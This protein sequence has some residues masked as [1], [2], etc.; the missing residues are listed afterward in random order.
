MN[1]LDTV[2]V[3][4]IEVDQRPNGVTHHNDDPFTQPMAGDHGGPMNGVVMEQQ[5]VMQQLP[6]LYDMDLERMQNDLFKGRYLTPQDFLDDVE[7]ILHNADVRAYEDPERLHKAQA[8][9]TAAQVSIQEFDPQLKVECERMAGRE[10]QR[11]EERRKEKGKDKAKDKEVNGV[12]APAGARR[13]ARANGLEPEH[14]IT[15]PVKLER[16]LKR[17]RGEES[18]GVDS[19]GSENEVNGAFDIDGRDSKRTRIIEERDD[20]RDPLDTLGSS[21]PGT[22]GRSHV[23]R[24]A[25]SIPVEPMAPLMEIPGP[26]HVSQLPQGQFNSSHPP[27]MPEYHNH[28]SSNM[29]HLAGVQNSFYPSSQ[30]SL[31][32]NPHNHMVV[33]ESPRPMGGF[34]P[35][36]LN[37]APMGQSPFHASPF[38]PRVNGT[39]YNFPVASIDPTDPFYIPGSAPPHS[40][41]IPYAQQVTKTPTPPLSHTPVPQPHL[42]PEIE[43]VMTSTPIPVTSTSVAREITPMVVEREPTPAPTPPPLPDFHVSPNLLSELR[44]LLKSKTNTLI[45]E[46]LEQL[47]AACLGTVWRYR[48]DWDR[49]VLVKVLLQEVKDFIQ[50][51]QEDVEEDL[52]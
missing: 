26:S 27:M 14:A 48:R 12:T 23:V 4:A 32:P 5:Q 11:R 15:D 29:G 18:S 6:P 20:D 28:D 46:Q 43:R 36:L 42:A 8:M 51:V 30:S 17:Q 34:D 33:D 37:P 35:S 47:R 22:E 50:E 31:I 10:R 13:S 21:R 45:I 2:N 39:P 44:Y 41:Q 1:G 19:H 38:V 16:R 40:S 9:F 25:T 52:N 7:K 24:F 49:D 3:A